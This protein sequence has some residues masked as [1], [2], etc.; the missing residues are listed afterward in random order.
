MKSY[1]IY[2]NSGIEWIGKIPKGWGVSRLKYIDKCVMGQ[3]P[4]SEK[5]NKDGVGIPFLQGNAD[6]MTFNPVPSVDRKSVV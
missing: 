1:P 2:K 4:E 6:F 3:S 5:C